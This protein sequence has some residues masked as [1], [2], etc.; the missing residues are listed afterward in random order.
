MKREDVHESWAPENDPWRA[1]V[2]PVLFA[3]LDATVTP[4]PMREAPGWIGP[5]L[6]EPLAAT[7]A[8][9]PGYR[10]N[11]AQRATALVIDLPGV[12]G[13]ELG[14]ALAQHGF[15]PVPLYNAVPAPPGSTC[16]VAVWPIMKALVDAAPIVRV[17]PTGLPPAFLLD[18]DRMGPAQTA[19]SWAFDNRSVCRASDFPS[20]E[21]LRAWGITRVVLVRDRAAA[22]LDEVAFD[23]QARGLALWSVDGSGASSA[24]PITLR[25]RS[26]ISRLGQRLSQSILSLRP[27][28]SYGPTISAGGH[29][30]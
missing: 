15:R 30:A 9:E 5:R 19:A 29:G 17:L 24:A 8:S 2:K 10:E 23:W 27:D 13:V 7:A 11:G 3:A 26:W 4:T 22:D 21:T 14:V 25:R 20:A 12:S 1:W 16:M 18:A 6:L 28:G